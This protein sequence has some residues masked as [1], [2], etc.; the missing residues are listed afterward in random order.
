VPRADA[1]EAP[2]YGTPAA[3][4]P[5]VPPANVRDVAAAV[6]AAPADVSVTVPEPP[7]T[8]DVPGEDTQE[9]IHHGCTAVSANSA[10]DN[11]NLDDTLTVPLPGPAR[12][13]TGE[14]ELSVPITGDVAVCSKVPAQPPSQVASCKPGRH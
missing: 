7:A 5:Y 1:A 13:A 10:C 11:A 6:P 2:S 14:H 3:A 12:D 4:D 8:V 9:S